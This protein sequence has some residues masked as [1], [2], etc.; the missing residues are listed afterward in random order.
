MAHRRKKPTTTSGDLQPEKQIH[1]AQ[2]GGIRGLHN[3]TWFWEHELDSYPELHKLWQRFTE[4]SHFWEATRIEYTT[5]G[6][7]LI[8]DSISTVHH[9]FVSNHYIQRHD[10]LPELASKFIHALFAHPA[11]AHRADTESSGR[12]ATGL[13]RCLVVVVVVVFF[14]AILSPKTKL[15]RSF[16]IY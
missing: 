5:T 16:R 6:R 2:T 12:Q 3:K 11:F 8:T 14:C 9:A 15:H 10:S 13:S 1:V 4:A 7:D